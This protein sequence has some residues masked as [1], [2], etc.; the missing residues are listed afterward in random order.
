MNTKSIVALCSALCI[1]SSHP[2]F[3]QQDGAV[4]VNPFGNALVPDMASI[5]LIADAFS[6]H[7]LDKQ[8]MPLHAP[9]HS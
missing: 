3:A 2:A 9:N 4:P 7:G 1:F 8:K 5:E 6:T